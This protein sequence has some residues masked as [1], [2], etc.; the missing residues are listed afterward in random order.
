MA[1]LSQNPTPEDPANT[2]LNILQFIRMYLK[3]RYVLLMS[4]L[5]L[6]TIIAPLAAN[7]GHYRGLYVGDLLTI[8]FL[9]I[10]F[11]T[12][13]K[14][15][16]HALYISI[17]V[18]LAIGCGIGSR[19]PAEPIMWL[20]ITGM[21][22]E[23]VLLVYMFLLISRDV[24][25][26]SEVNADTLCGSVSVYLLIAAF[27]GMIYSIILLVDPAAFDGIAD[28]LSTDPTLGPN[29][30]MLYYSVITLTTLGYG[31]ITPT[32]QYTRSLAT[33]EV[34]IGQLYLTV[35]VARLVGQHL[36]GM[37]MKKSAHNE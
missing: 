14:V 2:N 34:I 35:M 11:L 8:T 20:Q 17:L 32:S 24:F 10:G 18:F 12:F 21:S 30:A 28:A 33:L 29:R 25:T 26:S 22:F 27:F 37:Q 23:V 13:V 15:G 3:G 7:W 5:F 6:M 4:G 16:H 36:V 19:M 1:E 9:V 31:D